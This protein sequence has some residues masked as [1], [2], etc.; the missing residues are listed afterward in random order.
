MKEERSFA[1]NSVP[2]L[3]ARPR[4]FEPPTLGLEMRRYVVTHS[5]QVVSFCYFL[6][7]ITIPFYKLWMNKYN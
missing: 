6:I 4:G 3:L 7:D 2:D 5:N 1:I